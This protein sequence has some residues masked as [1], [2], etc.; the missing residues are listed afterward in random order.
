MAQQPQIHFSVW[1]TNICVSEILFYS[2][3]FYASILYELFRQDFIRGP[4][5]GLGMQTPIHPCLHAL[6]VK[7]GIILPTASFFRNILQAGI[8]DRT[9]S[10]LVVREVAR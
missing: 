8:Q 2:I 1:L 5:R 7:C 4:L 10:A 6:I 9:W 3:L